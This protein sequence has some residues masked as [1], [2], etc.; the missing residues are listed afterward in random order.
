[1][2][3][4]HT[5]IKAILS[6]FILGGLIFPYMAFAN[7]PETLAVLS[8]AINADKNKNLNYLKKGISTMLYSR[9]TWPEKVVVVPPKKI[10]ALEAGLKEFSGSKLIHA[11]AAKTGS[12]YVL[13]GTI[14]SLAD[15]FSIDAKVFDTTEKQYMAF[16]EQSKNSDDLIKKMDRIAAAINH[17]VFHRTTV[18]WEQ[19]E[20]EKQKQLNA[21]KNQNPEKLM[22][23]PTGW[24]REE[25]VG[26]KVWKYLF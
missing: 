20:Q 9:L 3:K 22:Q 21:L 25:K 14:T 17:K 26:W 7:P 8:F 19:M 12:R 15:A 6:V 13:Y 5:F 24:Q 16:F 10:A 11:V 23:M 18:T 1:M 4:P 2:K